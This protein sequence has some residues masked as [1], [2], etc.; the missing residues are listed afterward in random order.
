[1]TSRDRKVY[2]PEVLPPEPEPSG[3]VDPGR[4]KWD[5]WKRTLGPVLIG[6]TVDVIDLATFGPLGLRSGF[7][8]GA[9]ATFLLCSLYDF[10]VKYR[11]LLA[12]SAGLYCMFPLTERLPLGTILGVV[13]RFRG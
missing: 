12:L 10:P 2:E 7:V 3:S 11:L 4:Q 8:L 9:L 1:M 6:L 5:R 13:T